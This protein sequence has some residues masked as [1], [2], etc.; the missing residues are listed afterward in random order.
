MYAAGTPILAAHDD[1]HQTEWPLKMPTLPAQ[2]HHLGATKRE[3]PGKG[4]LHTYQAKTSDKHQH[5]SNAFH[6]KININPEIPTII[7]WPKMW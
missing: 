1:C 7:W 5:V 4:Q 3:L 6:P 2:S